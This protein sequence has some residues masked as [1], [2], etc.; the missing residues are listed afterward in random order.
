MA[1][2]AQSAASTW[3]YSQALGRVHSVGT[4]H[5]QWDWCRGISISSLTAFPPFPHLSPRC[6]SLPRHVQH[7]MCLVTS[8]AL[9]LCSADAGMML[10]HVV[11]TEAKHPWEML[12]PDLGS[13]F[14]LRDKKKKRQKGSIDMHKCT[15]WSNTSN[16]EINHVKTH[17]WKYVLM[18][19]RAWVF[20]FKVKSEPGKG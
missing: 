7:L 20:Q 16:V 13:Q 18:T 1:W 4:S 6:C 2:W 17:Y 8:Q 5:P 9:S 15:E 14:A 11:Y 19:D 10:W 3:I 12:G